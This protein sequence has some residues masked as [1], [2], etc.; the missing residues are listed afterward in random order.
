MLPH[1][2]EVGRGKVSLILMLEHWSLVFMKLLRRLS[3]S[4][5]IISSK[6]KFLTILENFRRVV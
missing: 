5:P 4:L 1:W 2:L 3:I 6:Q